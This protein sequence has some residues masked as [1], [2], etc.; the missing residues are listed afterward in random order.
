MTEAI[1][2]ERPA[3]RSILELSAFDQD[4]VLIIEAGNTLQADC[5]RGSRSDF[6]SSRISPVHAESP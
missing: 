4:D 1:S 5:F 2:F 3:R 6:V